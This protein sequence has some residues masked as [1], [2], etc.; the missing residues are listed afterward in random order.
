MNETTRLWLI[1]HQ[2][3]ECLS[4]N[5]CWNPCMLKECKEGALCH[6]SQQ[7]YDAYRAAENVV[8]RAEN[9]HIGQRNI[10]QTLTTAALKWLTDVSAI[11]CHNYVPRIIKKF[12]TVRVKLMCWKLS[13]KCH[14]EEVV[15]SSK[16]MALRSPVKN[17][18][19]KSSK[20][21]QF[22]WLKLQISL[23]YYC[24]YSS[25]IA[26]HWYMHINLSHFIVFHVHF[27]MNRNQS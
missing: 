9:T 25:F 2:N 20:T 27:I 16:S 26:L 18:S 5:R 11:E 14:K 7:V 12:L 19:K 15:I 4:T 17:I 3:S 8:R 23:F 22:G 6:P 24:F 13:K 1:L 10:I 21:C